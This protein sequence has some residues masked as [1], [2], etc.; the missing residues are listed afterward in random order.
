MPSPC[1]WL[2]WGCLAAQPIWPTAIRKS[3][4]VCRCFCREGC[5]NRAEESFSA[6]HA[7]RKQS[8][9]RYIT[10]QENVSRVGTGEGSDRS[11]PARSPAPGLHSHPSPN[12]AGL[13]L[14]GEEENH[15]EKK[16][17]KRCTAHNASWV[18][19]ASACATQPFEWIRG[20]GN[21]AAWL[22]DFFFGFWPV[23]CG[24]PQEYK[25]T[26][27]SLDRPSQFVWW[28]LKV[29]RVERKVGARERVLTLSVSPQPPYGWTVGHAE[30]C[31]RYLAVTVTLVSNFSVFGGLGISWCF[32]DG[33]DDA[34]GH[35]GRTSH[36]ANQQ[37][38]GGRD[39]L[40]GGVFYFLTLRRTLTRR[41]SW[42]RAAHFRLIACHFLCGWQVLS[43]QEFRRLMEHALLVGNIM[44]GTAASGISLQ[45]ISKFAETKAR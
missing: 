36:V 20:I 19:V 4:K 42:V 24:G 6:R 2:S 39:S 33:D 43:S 35:F 17:A 27:T 28:L 15:G 26:V 25:G 18:V 37:G 38:A 7:A 23:A 13:H 1:F 11:E 5:A 31:I 8:W 45:S 14:V 44:N 10:H 16:I 41:R 30:I 3:E 12:A 21:Y 40:Y 34:D 32:A 22:R 29:P 9:H